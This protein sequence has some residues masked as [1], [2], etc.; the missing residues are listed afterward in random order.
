MYCTVLSVCILFRNDVYSTRHICSL[1][2]RTV[3]S[4]LIGITIIKAVIISRLI[5][6]LFLLAWHIQY[7]LYCVILYYVKITYVLSNQLQSFLATN[8]RWL[9]DQ[10]APSSFSLLLVA[11]AA[12]PPTFILRSYH[13]Y[14]YWYCTCTR[15]SALYLQTSVR[16]NFLLSNRSLIFSIS[17]AS[18]HSLM[19]CPA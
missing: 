12:N 15:S 18:F 16:L 8:S 5:S 19:Q 14:M 10:N 3:Y 17:T 13:W 4:A 1:I 2:E 9:C 11:I 6:I 7:T